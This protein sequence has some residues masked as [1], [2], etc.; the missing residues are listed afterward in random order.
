MFRCDVL[1]MLLLSDCEIARDSHGVKSV[2]MFARF[3]HSLL[4]ASRQAIGS[5]EGMLGGREAE[6][7]SGVE[8]NWAEEERERE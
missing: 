8:W 6:R 2:L 1:V 5:I 4:Q 3:R 7:K